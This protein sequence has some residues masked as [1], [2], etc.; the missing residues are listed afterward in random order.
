M[1]VKGYK[2]VAT[3]ASNKITVYSD[4]NNCIITISGSFNTSTSS[5]TTLTTID[6][7]YAPIYTS[8]SNYS[9]T[10]T[11]FYPISI[12]SEGKIQI[13]KTNAASIGIYTSLFYKI[14]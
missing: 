14:K 1:N 11:S 12:N 2:T 5:A 3:Y 10:S 6:T 7:K 13:S 4:G 9:F 8:M